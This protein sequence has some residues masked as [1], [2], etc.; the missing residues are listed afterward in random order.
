MK[1]ALLTL[2][3]VTGSTAFAGKPAPAPEKVVC[4]MYRSAAHTNW[5]DDGKDGIDLLETKYA[6]GVTMPALDTCV[7]VAGVVGELHGR[8]QFITVSAAT[9]QAS[10][11]CGQ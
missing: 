10:S 2:A 9:A 3:L 5:L 4:G 7:C 6:P 1:I 11:V 8:T